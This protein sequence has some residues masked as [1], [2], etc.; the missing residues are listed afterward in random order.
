[1]TTPADPRKRKSARATMGQEMRSSFLL[2]TALGLAILLIG[3]VV[4]MF[5]PWPFTQTLIVLV[6]ALLLAWLLWSSR[7]ASWG[8]RLLALLVALPAVAGVS[9]G[10]VDGSLAAALLG[11]G[12]TLLL[13]ALLRFLQT[14]LSFRFAYGRFRDGD[15]E[16]ALELADK[17]IAARPDFW[18]SYQLRAM[19]ELSLLQLGY[20]ERDA[21]QA[22]ALR[23]DAHPAWNTLG[24]IYLAEEEFAAAEEA[25]GRALDAAPGY[26]LYLYHLGLA[27]FRQGKFRPA[28]ESFAAATQGTLPTAAYDL[29]ARYYLARALEALGEPAAAA[30]AEAELA[31]F[32]FALPELQESL[33]AQPEYPHLAQMRADLGDLGGRVETAVGGAEAEG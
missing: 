2:P 26:A 23:P 19:I 6:A 10:L 22:T 17:A 33:A 18:E 28:A 16:G 21:R 5:S 24:H 20:A 31:K 15:L 13:L 32:A 25:Y 30:Q 14:P 29:Q 3:V 12:V 11:M 4:V 8:L 27:E 1:M 9:V 7:A